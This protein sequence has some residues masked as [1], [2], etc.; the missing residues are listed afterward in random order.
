MPA[1]ASKPAARK[2]R[3]GRSDNVH[4]DTSL[5]RSAHGAPSASSFPPQAAA[6]ALPPASTL[7]AANAAA[8][9][10]STDGPSL[11]AFGLAPGELIYVNEQLSRVAGVDSE[12]ILWVDL[13]LDVENENENENEDDD[14]LES[15]S[16]SLPSALAPTAH[17]PGDS[18]TEV[19]EHVHIDFEAGRARKDQ[20]KQQKRAAA[21]A[22][23]AAAAVAAYALEQAKQQQRRGVR[24]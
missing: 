23:V 20:R 15:K 7:T 11:S 3:K 19:P 9:A 21:S 22:A 2:V 18:M 8:P 10:L 13:L 1:L 4:F 17:R 6:A 12:G 16:L 24:R 14:D 5:A